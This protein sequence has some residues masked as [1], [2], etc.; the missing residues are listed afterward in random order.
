MAVFRI[1]P[2]LQAGEDHVLITLSSNDNSSNGTRTFE[3]LMT[4]TSDPELFRLSD[5]ETNDT[6]LSLS[7]HSLEDKFFAIVHYPWKGAYP[8]VVFESGLV[9]N[10]LRRYREDL[11][12]IRHHLKDDDTK[13]KKQDSEIGSMMTF[14]NGRVVIK[15]KVGTAFGCSKEIYVE[16]YKEAYSKLNTSSPPQSRGSCWDISYQHVKDHLFTL[17][18][19]HRFVTVKL[20]EYN[21]LPYFK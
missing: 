14:A 20:E 8:P 12:T 6:I 9:M 15:D 11:E 3:G 19:D 18:K 16:L 2:F 13:V 7:L 1:I 17:S 21:V 10:E 5:S 4:K